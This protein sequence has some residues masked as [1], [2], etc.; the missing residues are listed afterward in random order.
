MFASLLLLKL[1][2]VAEAKVVRV[3]YQLLAVKTGHHTML[4][5]LFIAEELAEDRTEL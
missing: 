2:D 3:P 4:E 1:V 5:G